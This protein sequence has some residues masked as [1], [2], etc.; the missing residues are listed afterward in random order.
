MFLDHV[1]PQ[2]LLCA[3]FYPHLY[4]YL[5]AHYPTPLGL[6]QQT[7]KGVV[8]EDLS[9]LKDAVSSSWE[10]RFGALVG[11][12]PV[13]CV[14]VCAGVC[15]YMCV[16][17]CV[18]NTTAA[19]TASRTGSRSAASRFAGRGDEEEVEVKK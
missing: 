7:L 5:H 13:R 17:V 6:L 18:C 1:F 11:P 3:L 2:I 14:C 8:G 9:P 15:V 10:G 4:L 16:C 12:L 19:E